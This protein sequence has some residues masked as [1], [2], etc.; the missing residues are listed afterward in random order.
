MIFFF[1]LFSSE[2]PTREI[3]LTIDDSTAEEV[4]KVL[5]KMDDDFKEG[6]IYFSTLLH[7]ISQMVEGKNDRQALSNGIKQFVNSLVEIL[8]IGQKRNKLSTITNQDELKELL[9]W[10]V[11]AL[12]E[13]LSERILS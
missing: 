8:M 11:H 7:G 4:E 13:P 5:R 3:E 1:S 9:L 12:E 10:T 2:S 6:L